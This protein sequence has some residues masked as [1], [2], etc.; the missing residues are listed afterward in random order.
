MTTLTGI[1][2][3]LSRAS[4]MR[5]SKRFSRCLWIVWQRFPPQHRNPTI[6]KC[7]P[8]AL[9]HSRGPGYPLA[10]GPWKWKLPWTLSP[11]WREQT[12]APSCGKWRK[13]GQHIN[14]GPPQP[15]SCCRQTDR[16]CIVLWFPRSG[17]HISFLFPP[18][19]RALGSTD[20]PP[21]DKRVETKG[22]LV[23]GT[24]SIQSTVSIFP[25]W[26]LRQWPPCISPGSV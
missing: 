7:C 23:I 2:Y 11:W 21:L 20:L 19:V 22:T 15:H 3:G 16:E 14:S 17:L 25:G 10:L 12:H 8:L 4:F 9:K 24:S 6:S 5:F 1:K 18:R 13:P 26:G